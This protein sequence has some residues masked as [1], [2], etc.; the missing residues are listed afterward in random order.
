MYVFGGIMVYKY[1]VSIV[2][3]NIVFRFI[4]MEKRLDLDDF[5]FN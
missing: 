5:I 3:E 1:L 2:F 4:D